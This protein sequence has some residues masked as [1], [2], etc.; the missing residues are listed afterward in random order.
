M[1]DERHNGSPSPESQ[2]VVPGEPIRLLLYSDHYY[3]VLPKNSFPQAPRDSI[4]VV[5]LLSPF[6]ESQDGSATPPEPGVETLR[7]SALN[8]HL[9]PKEATMGQLEPELLTTSRPIEPLLTKD[10][11]QVSNE[12]KGPGKVAEVS[13]APVALTAEEVPV[14]DQGLSFRTIGDVSLG[15]FAGVGVA[16]A[17]YAMVKGGQAL[18]RFLKGPNWTK[19]RS[20]KRRMINFVHEE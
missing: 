12:I 6:S 15:F 11:T 20:R 16:T 8:D 18:W 17:I 9:T 14:K 7:G 2:R 5:R 4:R 1:D 10:P 13:Q 3:P 19:G